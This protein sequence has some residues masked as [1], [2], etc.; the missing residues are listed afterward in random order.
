MERCFLRLVPGDEQRS[1]RCDRVDH[2]VGDLDTPGALKVAAHRLRQRWRRQLVEEVADSAS[3]IGQLIAE[4]RAASDEQ[5][6]GID[7]INRAVTE[8]DKVVQQNAANAE[9]SA[10]ASEEMNAQAEQMKAVVTELVAII[11]G[12][13]QRDQAQVAPRVRKAVAGK[14]K[15]AR[16]PARR[17]PAAATASAGSEM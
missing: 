2:V 5:A 1:V 10:S 15:P 16:V 12:S 14:M 4:I 8:M 7:Q 17:T 11:G 9:E 6:Q 13:D 3:K